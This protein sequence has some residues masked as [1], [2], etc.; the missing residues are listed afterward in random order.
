MRAQGTVFVCMQGPPGPSPWPHCPPALAR[1]SRRAPGLWSRPSTRTGGTPVP[2]ARP[3]SAAVEPSQP[4]SERP[5]CS[6]AQPQAPLPS[7]CESG[8]RRNEGLSACSGGCCAPSLARRKRGG[9]PPRACT[10]ARSPSLW[11]WRLAEEGP[12]PWPLPGLGGPSPRQ[13]LASQPFPLCG[14][15]AARGPSLLP[16]HPCSPR[17]KCLVQPS[18]SRPQNGPGGGGVCGEPAPPQG[19]C[20]QA[21]VPADTAPQACRS[22]ATAASVLEPSSHATFPA[23]ALSLPPGAE[24]PGC[25]PRAALPLSWGSTAGMSRKNVPVDM[26]I[27]QCCNFV[28]SNHVNTCMDFI[29]YILY[30]NL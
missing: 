9:S 20:C 10:S 16:Q 11:G 14:A 21:W 17:I 15:R 27:P 1:A 26:Y 29:I 6:R 22:T 30:V 3:G 23:E 2:T 25:A 8:D 13:A 4:A 24:R 28:C 12:A 5:A 18:K 7:C 19:W